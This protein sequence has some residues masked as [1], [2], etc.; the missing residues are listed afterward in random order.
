MTGNDASPE[1]FRIEIK[2]DVV[3]S[4]L[5]RLRVVLAIMLEVHGPVDDIHLDRQ[6]LFITL[7]CDTTPDGW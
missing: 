7:H 3:Q 1:R 6:Y 5:V 2:L 4:N